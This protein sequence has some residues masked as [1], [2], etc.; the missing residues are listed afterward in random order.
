MA[1]T[2]V[3]VDMPALADVTPDGARE[4]SS[5]AAIAEAWEAALRA[6]APAQH[7]GTPLVRKLAAQVSRQLGLG[8][9]ERVAVDVCAQIRDIGMIKLPD[10]VVLKTGPLSPQD[11]ALLNRHP[12]LG[13][14]RLSGRPSRQGDSSAQSRRRRL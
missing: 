10:S 5:I 3:T 11:W 4:A 9:A 13:A 8:R 1:A 12:E 14:Q 7:A 6:R 2:S